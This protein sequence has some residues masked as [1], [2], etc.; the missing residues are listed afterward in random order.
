MFPA[1]N[2]C[3]HRNGTESEWEVIHEMIAGLPKVLRLFAM[4]LEPGHTDNVYAL[5]LPKIGF[6][7]RTP[8]VF[9]CSFL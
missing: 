3:T 2:S 1:Y 8:K 4:V 5:P 6:Q 7:G 9:Q